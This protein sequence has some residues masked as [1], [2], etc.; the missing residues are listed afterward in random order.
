MRYDMLLD[1]MRIIYTLYKLTFY[2]ISKNMQ[3]SDVFV[4]HLSTPKL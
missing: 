1:V 3:F 4:Y 2:L